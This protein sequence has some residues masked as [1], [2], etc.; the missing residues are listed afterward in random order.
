MITVAVNNFKEWRAVA[1]R[2]ILQNTPPTTVIWTSGANAQTNLLSGLEL[3]AAAGA[4]SK[5]FTVP[6]TFMSY[7]EAI[8]CHRNP[9]RF[10]KLYRALW[11]ITHGEKHLME[12]KSDPLLHEL[13]MYYRAIRRDVHKMKAFV[14][15]KLHKEEDED[16]YLAWYKPDH[17]IMRLA[18]PFFQRR[19]SVMKWT[20]MTPG[21]TASWDGDELIFS[22]GVPTNVNNVEDQLE[23][24]WCTYYSAI[25]NPARIKIKAMKNEMPIRFWHNLPEAATIPTILQEAPARVAKM[26]REQEGSRMSAKDYFPEQ[27]TL[28]ALEQAAKTCEGCPIYQC[29]RQTVFGRGKADASLMI[30]G[31]QPGLQ[32]DI[33]GKP[34][35]GPAGNVLREELKT[36]AVNPENLYL[37][38]AVKHFKNVKVN[39]RQMHRSPGVKEVNACKPWLKAE[40]DIVKPKVILCLGVTPAKALINPGFKMTNNHGKWQAYGESSSTV[41]TATYHPAALL[42]APT[43]EMKEEMFKAFRHDLRTALEMAAD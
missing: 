40:I 31:E 15:F 11:R 8:A 2:H 1:K 30:V 29:A 32:E 18:A 4:P 37:T 17:N 3:P 28:S 22:A 23:T 35:V 26:M 16:F 42:R 5:S 41:I 21:E 10:D 27:M 14:R 6:K 25:F 12:I 36:L 43:E 34:F 20:I 13:Y 24:L 7:A 9:D 33:E 19:F 39:G 38:N